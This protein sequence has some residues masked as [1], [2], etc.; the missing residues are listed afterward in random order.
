MS[1]QRVSWSR[2]QYEAYCRRTGTLPAPAEPRKKGATA[3]RGKNKTEAEFEAWFK[4]EH[5]S[6]TL[7]FETIKLRID[8]TCWYLPDYFC[9]E[10]LTFYEVKNAWIAEDAVIKFKACRALYP[11]AKWKMIQK[12]RGEW[13]EIRKLP[14]EELNEGVI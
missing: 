9:P 6:C 14:G 12:W 8:A 1:G 5:P 10:M 2:D 7:L 3:P 13:R 4:R 11:W